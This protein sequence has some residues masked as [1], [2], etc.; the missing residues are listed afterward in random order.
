M[1]H[2]KADSGLLLSAM[3]GIFLV[4][5]LSA[6]GVVSTEGAIRA[7]FL[8]GA[9]VVGGVSVYELI[10]RL[11]QKGIDSGSGDRHH[12]LKGKGRRE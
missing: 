3:I 9:G 1:N 8:Y 7:G 5:A 2:Q 12:R 6:L 10:R 4:A 11:R